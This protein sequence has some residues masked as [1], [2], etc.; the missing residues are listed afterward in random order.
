MQLD[1]SIVSVITLITSACVATATVLLPPL[2]TILAE[3]EKWKRERIAGEIERI[4]K[5]TRDLLDILSDVWASNYNNS[6][7]QL[8]Y[9]KD[10]PEVQST[11]FSRAHMWET[12][13]IPYCRKPDQKRIKEI[14]RKIQIKP[15][16]TN[17]VEEDKAIR[18]TLPD[19]IHEMSRIAKSGVK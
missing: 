16:G 7:G 6:P 13:L 4:D 9:R 17:S 18:A 2:L 11:L 10:F 19:E 14:N 12:T 5:A 3:R 1:P 15:P 8:K